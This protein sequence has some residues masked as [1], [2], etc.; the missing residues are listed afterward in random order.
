MKLIINKQDAIDMFS[1]KYPDTKIEDVIFVDDDGNTLSSV[2][3]MEDGDG[4][5]D[6]YHKYLGLNVDTSP[7]EL[8]SATGIVNI[9]KKSLEDQGYKSRIPENTNKT[10]EDAAEEFLNTL[11]RRDKRVFFDILNIKGIKKF[12][13]LWQDYHTIIHKKL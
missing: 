12:L 8:V 1:Q 13:I 11:K 2:S 4:D 5:G 9:V 10:C 6:D 7:E 3:E